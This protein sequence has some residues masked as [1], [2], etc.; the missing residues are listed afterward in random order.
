MS[1]LISHWMSK[2]IDIRASR[3][4]CAFCRRSIFGQRTPW[5]CMCVFVYYT[6]RPVRSPRGCWENHCRNSSGI[7][8]WN[9]PHSPPLS[10]YPQ[11]PLVA[12]VLVE[13]AH[14]P[15][16]DKPHN[17]ND[18]YIY[19]CMTSVGQALVTHTASTHVVNFLLCSHTRQ[20]PWQPPPIHPHPS[21]S[22]EVLE[23]RANQHIS[24]TSFS[25]HRV[26]VFCFLF[27]FRRTVGTRGTHDK[28]TNG[29]LWV[30]GQVYTIYIHF[31][32]DGCSIASFI[33]EKRHRWFEQF[34]RNHSG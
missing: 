19:I 34:W 30:A 15:S 6:I 8:K 4:R 20:I 18:I 13:H 27:L 5:R 26:F 29:K 11:P 9:P 31:E 1:N 28:H 33:N 21:D 12:M 10:A 23:K 7:G 3:L 16:S 24:F 14:I 17:T 2:F 32:F 22:S 25:S